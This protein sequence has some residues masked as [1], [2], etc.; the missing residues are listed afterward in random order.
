VGDVE[1]TAHSPQTT[2]NFETFPLH[3]GADLAS[4][5]VDLEPMWTV[6]VTQRRGTDHL[7]FIFIVVIVLAGYQ[8]YQD[9]TQQQQATDH[10][11][12]VFLS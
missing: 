9:C 11:S 10:S 3:A 6:K 2:V 1:D 12:Q 7:Y 8:G 4:M 5:V